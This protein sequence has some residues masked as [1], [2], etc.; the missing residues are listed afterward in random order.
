MASAVVTTPPETPMSRQ[1]FR[2][3][4][5]A[6]PHGRFERIDG[7]AVAMAPERV[8]LVRVKARAWRALDDAVRASGL[9]CEVFADGAT[10]EVDNN[11][12]EPDAVLRCG[13][14]LPGDTIAVPDP[15]IVV[16]VLSPGTRANDVTRKLVAYFRIPSVRHY[17][18]F[19]ADRPHVIHHRRRDDG[20]GVETRILAEGEIVL[21]PPGIRVAVAEVY[22][23]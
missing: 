20:D 23:G 6:R 5:E 3:W 22:G 10:V 8:A 14:R 4:V 1:E 7:L 19:F 18:V 15:V 12:F 16:E 21:D 17:L 9:D 11:D 2:R 13:P